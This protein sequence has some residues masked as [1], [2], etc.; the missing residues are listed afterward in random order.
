M[1]G[2]FISAGAGTEVT[3]IPV[4]VETVTDTGARRQFTACHYLVQL[5]PSAQDYVP[6]DPIRIDFTEERPAKGDVKTLE[7]HDC[8]F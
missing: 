8:R 5:S 4:A 2:G 3:V 6:F 7:L 1:G